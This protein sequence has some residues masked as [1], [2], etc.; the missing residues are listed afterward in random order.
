MIVDVEEIY[1]RYKAFWRKAIAEDAQVIKF[2]GMNEDGIGMVVAFIA[3]ADE[4]YTIDDRL[5]LMMPE[6]KALA[7]ARDL[8]GTKWETAP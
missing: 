4:I 6:E 3:R 7:M 2:D 8:L 1:E 5:V